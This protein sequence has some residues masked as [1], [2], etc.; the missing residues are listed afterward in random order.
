MISSTLASRRDFGGRTSPCVSMP[1]CTTGGMASFLAGA[2]PSISWNSLR[3]SLSRGTIST[4][5]SS[6]SWPLRHARSGDEAPVE[7]ARRIAAIGPPLRHERIELLGLPKL[8]RDAVE[9]LGPILHL[10]LVEHEPVIRVGQVLPIDQRIPAILRVLVVI[11]RVGLL[12]RLHD[13]DSAILQV[14]GHHDLVRHD[15]D[16]LRDVATEAA[17]LSAQR[18]DGH[19]AEC[20]RRQ[21]IKP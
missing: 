4:P 15:A 14:N 20:R 3:F 12:H 1:Y 16:A 19:R 18:T 7:N 8:Q 5:F 21:V 13:L 17:H 11:G 6:S 10:A 2:I 9:P